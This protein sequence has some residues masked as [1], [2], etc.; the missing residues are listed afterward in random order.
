MVENAQVE[1]THTRRHSRG[2]GRRVLVRRQRS[3]RRRLAGQGAGYICVPAA[4]GPQSR[5]SGGACWARIRRRTRLRPPPAPT[6]TEP[7]LRTPPAARLQTTRLRLHRLRPTPPSGNLQTQTPDA[8]GQGPDSAQSPSGQSPDNPG[9]EQA[10]DSSASNAGQTGQ[11]DPVP[12][13]P[14]AG[15]SPGCEI[16]APR[17]TPA[18]CPSTAGPSWTIWIWLDPEKAELVPE[19]GW[20]L[21]PVTVSFYE[22]ESVF[23]VLQRVC[24]QE[25]IHMEFSNTPIY[26]SAYIEGIHNLYEF[27]YGRAFWLDVQGERLVP[28]LRLLPLPAQRRGRDRVGLHLRFGRGCG[29]R[30]RR[31]QSDGP[32]APDAAMQQEGLQCSWR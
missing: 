3:Q 14:A 2:A 1:I 26:N 11:T 10:P 16:P 29:R 23:N 22:G 5:R 19:D 15:G 31:R 18:P 32:I 17:P 24:K 21:L 8:A 20:V 6:A 30:L 7:L 4:A 27:D 9:P 28:Q 25:K 13:E 12:E